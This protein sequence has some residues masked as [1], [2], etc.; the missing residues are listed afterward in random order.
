VYGTEADQLSPVILMHLTKPPP[1]EEAT[2]KL[3]EEIVECC[4]AKGVM[5]AVNPGTRLDLSRPTPS[6]RVLVTA[7]HTLQDLSVL[8][9][10]F[11]FACREVL[12][13]PR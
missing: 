3:L 8:V 13:G 7:V 6:I 10:A 5:V 1:S 2:L 11:G 4:L 9:D 12:R